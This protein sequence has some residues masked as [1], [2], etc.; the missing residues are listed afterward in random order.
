MISTSKT[1]NFLELS[2]F[3]LEKKREV[4]GNCCHVFLEKILNYLY[5]VENLFK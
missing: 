1:F 4:G 3:A 2:L 5:L